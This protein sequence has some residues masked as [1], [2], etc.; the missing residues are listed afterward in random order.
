MFWPL[1]V[2]LNHM[3]SFKSFF[4]KVGQVCLHLTLLEVFTPLLL[5]ACTLHPQYL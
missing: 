3:K 2:I 4:F 5:A 1:V